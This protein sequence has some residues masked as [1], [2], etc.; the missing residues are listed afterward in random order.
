MKITDVKIRYVEGIVTAEA[1]L[2][3]GSMGAKVRYL[4]VDNHYSA[5]LATDNIGAVASLGPDGQRRLVETFLCIETDE[6]ITGMAGPLNNTAQVSMLITGAFRAILIGEDPLNT[7]RIWDILYRKDPF[8]LTGVTVLVISFCDIALWDIKCKKAGLPLWQM[9]GGATQQVLSA[10]ANC[11]GCAYKEDGTGYDL[12]QVAKQTQW[13]VDNGFTGAKWYPHRGPSGL[14]ELYEMFK[15]IREVGGPDFKLMMD[16]W[17][18]WDVS[19]TLK[20]A[21]KLAPLDLYWIEEP[22]MPNR[23]DA[24]V[25]LQRNSPIPISA[26]ENLCTR[27]SFKPYLDQEALD[28]YQP[29][30]VWCGGISETL[31]I[32]SMIDLYDKRICL[33]GFSVPIAAQLA[34]AYTANVC[35][36]S[37]FLL[38]ITPARQFFFKNPVLAKGGKLYLPPADSAGV[39][40]DIDETKVVRSWYMD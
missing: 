34:A 16:V 3:S 21:E 19:Y 12:D 35:P 1:P 25:T 13:C 9:V 11:T 37:E 4:P 10:Y 14:R 2:Y 22:V 39:G 31:K 26:G 6:G 27:W 17:S 30:P 5:A 24:Y 33:H 18:A 40:M 28:I 38:T 8:S 29:D 20:A 23:I 7:E 32:M 36:I 15:I